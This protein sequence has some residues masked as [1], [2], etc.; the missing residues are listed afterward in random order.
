MDPS[1]EGLW[2]ATLL[3][4]NKAC[5]RFQNVVAI[6]GASPGQLHLGKPNGPVLPASSLS[7][8]RTPALVKQPVVKSPEVTNSGG[9]K[10]VPVPVP[11]QKVDVKAPVSAP[12]AAAKTAAP[13]V[14]TEA[15]TLASAPESADDAASGE[16]AADDPYTAA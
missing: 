5:K 2:S 13:A 9:A 10:A 16:C 1:T 11:P 4:T 6:V 14:E 3:Q 15:K 7:A 8:S 12:E